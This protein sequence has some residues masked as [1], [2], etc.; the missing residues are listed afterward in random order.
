MHV[1]YMNQHLSGK[2]IAPE[3]H[4]GYK[5]NVQALQTAANGQT[6]TVSPYINARGITL[7][8]QNLCAIA[9][10]NINC[11]IALNNF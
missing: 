2:Q 4:A 11:N 10:H 7:L 6:S 1:L 5:I 9:L 3:K 8:V